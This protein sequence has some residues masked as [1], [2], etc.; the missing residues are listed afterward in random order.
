[1]F[2]HSQCQRETNEKKVSRKLR[3][4]NSCQVNCIEMINGEE[5]STKL[6]GQVVVVVAVVLIFLVTVNCV[7]WVFLQGGACKNA[8]QTQGP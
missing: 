3:G 4:K 1:M 5:G 2:H 6:V 7:F 8:C